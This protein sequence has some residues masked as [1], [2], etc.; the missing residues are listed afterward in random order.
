MIQIEN[1]KKIFEGNEAVSDLNL[2]IKKGTIYGLLGSNGA[3]KT[4]LLKMIAGIYKEDS[5]SIFVD[6]QPIYEN[7]KLKQ[8]TILLT[9]TLY[10][11]PQSTV[12]QMASFMKNMYP[13]WNEERFQ[14]YKEVFPININ[15]KIHLMSKGMQR[16]VAFWLALAAMPDVLILDEPLDGLDAVMRQKVKNLLVQ[17]VAEREMT[18]LISSHNLREVEDLCDHIG[19]L[20]NGKLIIEKELDDLKSDIHKIQVAFKGEVP[21]LFL[22][23]FDILYKEQRGSVLLYIVRG[24]EEEVSAHIEFYHPVLFDVLPLTLEE[25][26]I[27]EMR[28]VGY[29][30]ENVIV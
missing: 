12:K 23:P 29:A 27:Y 5:G 28:D 2:F 22:K 13:K 11:F 6:G 8:R 19:I 26:F 25:I 30:I 16:Q 3:G 14:K 20:H 24:K 10:F 1:I 18:I 9:D 17:E 15:K 21:E 7:V 4:T